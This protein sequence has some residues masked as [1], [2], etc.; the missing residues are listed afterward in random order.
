M[1]SFGLAPCGNG[2]VSRHSLVSVIRPSPN[3]D[4]RPRWVVD[5]ALLPGRVLL[6]FIL[7]MVVLALMVFGL[8]DVVRGE[9]WT[10]FRRR[11]DSFVAN[12]H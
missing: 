5:L 11:R 3:A 6:G 12:V 9:F 8:V 2:S 1:V 4:F 7:G 10:W